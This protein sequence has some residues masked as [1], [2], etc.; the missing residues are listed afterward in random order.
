MASTFCLCMGFVGANVLQWL[1]RLRMCTA[2]CLGV[3]VELSVR[4]YMN[5]CTVLVC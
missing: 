3:Y 1:V 2:I 4:T 5:I